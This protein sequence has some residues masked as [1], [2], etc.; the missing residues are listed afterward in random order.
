MMAMKLDPERGEIHEPIGVGSR[1]ADPSLHSSEYRNRPALGR[2][3]VAFD[4]QRSIERQGG[5]RAG[6]DD[7]RDRGKSG[8]TGSALS[9]KT[10]MPGG[11]F[12]CRTVACAASSTW[13]R[14]SGGIR[15]S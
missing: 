13:M 6:R 9:A 7:R 14:G 4:L 1:F 15:P 2:L 10:R 12:R 8:Q 11:A 5:S 3:Y